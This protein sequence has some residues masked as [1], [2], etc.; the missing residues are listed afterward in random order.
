MARFRMVSVSLT[1][2]SN[3]KCLTGTTAYADSRISA[4]TFDV[5]VFDGSFIHL[6]SKGDLLYAVGIFKI[7]L[8]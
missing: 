8:M 2:R 4:L 3:G 5:I 6:N 7:R 1:R